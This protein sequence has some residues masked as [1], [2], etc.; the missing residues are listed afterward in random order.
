MGDSINN[1]EIELD[2]AQPAKSRIGINSSEGAATSAWQIPTGVST[3]T[4]DYVRGRRIAS[5]YD[6]FLDNDPLTLADRKILD[7]YLPA[8]QYV[9]PI[10]KADVPIVAD[11]GCGSG[12][13]SIRLAELGYNV[14]AVDLS[15][16]MLSCLQQKIPGNQP[17]NHG[18]LWTLQ[19]NLVELDAVQTDCLDH[20]ICMF[21]TLGM[22]HGRRYRKQFLSHV[23]RIVKPDGQFILHVHNIWFQLRHPGGLSW[24]LSNFMQTL[25]GKS[26][27]GDRFAEY[28]GIKNM[29][30]HSFR[31]RELQ[32]DLRH[33]G[34]DQMH[35]FGIRANETTAVENPNWSSVFQ[36]VGWIVVCR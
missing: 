13:H 5:E 19:A 10:Q 26:E 30:I 20:A 11:L 23:R 3:G 2:D 22:I 25:Q 35:W 36:D 29:F 12:W 7:R 8:I 18:R 16:P 21:S 27:L 6:Q 1:G 33:S 32:R 15:L 24:L 14:L 34:F 9:E 28:R 31:R 17:V 4:W